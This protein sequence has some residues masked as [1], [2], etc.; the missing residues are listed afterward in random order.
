MR[1]Q[2][3]PRRLLMSAGYEVVA[4]RGGHE[5]IAAVE[6]EP[7]R[8]ALV[9]LDL[10]MPELDGRETHDR[11]KRLR[12]SLP[13][14]LMSGYAE[15]DASDRFVGSALAGFLHKPF[16]MHALQQAVAEILASRAGSRA[17]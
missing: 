1:T 10:T 2:H 6:A 17:T 4:A 15:Q 14:L 5:A 9:V 7:D 13:V 11:L 16:T 12:P 8:F 3:R